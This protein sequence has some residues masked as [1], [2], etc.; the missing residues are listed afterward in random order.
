MTLARPAPAVL[1]LSSCLAGW[2]HLPRC[3]D[4][5]SARRQGPPCRLLGHLRLASTPSQAARERGTATVRRS[6]SSPGWASLSAPQVGAPVRT[7]QS[8][9][10]PVSGEV[11]HP[12]ATR[13]DWERRLRPHRFPGG[14]RPSRAR[15]RVVR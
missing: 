3:P 13:R 1:V 14:A 7:G 11:L 9:T 5:L 12:E 2:A 15:V 10:L 8:V 4:A 6:Q